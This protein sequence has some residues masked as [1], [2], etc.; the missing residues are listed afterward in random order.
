MVYTLNLRAEPVTADC[1]LTDND[2]M[3][4]KKEPPSV[5]QLKTTLLGIKPPIWRQIQVPS[6]ILLCCL[7]DA[8]QAV[9]GW[10]D[11]HLHQFEKD[12]KYWGVPEPYDELDDIEI[13]DESRVP[14][15]RVLKTEGDSLLYVYDFGDNWQHKVVLEKILPATAVR[16]RPTCLGGERHCPPEDVGGV[17]G[18]ESFLDAIF[19]PAH[20]EYESYLTWV[21]GSLQAEEFDLKAVNEVLSRMRWPA[22]HRR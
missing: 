1:G 13:I 12:G 3:P 2:L 22:R 5:H 9:I 11:S 18:Y 19:D 16:S 6:T 17:T 15:G 4:P 20:E 14:V 7:H 8:L 10:T 21:G